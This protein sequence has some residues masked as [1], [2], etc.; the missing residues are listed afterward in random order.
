MT[1]TVQ[2][3]DVIFVLGLLC[4]V[5]LFGCLA[6]YV[7]W[8]IHQAQWIAGVE[9]AAER[10]GTEPTLD[11]L[12]EYEEESIHLGMSKEQTHQELSNVGE[13]QFH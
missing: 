7:R 1:K 10:L 11:G 2:Y 8:R 5:C 6:F 9:K 3:K 4:M 12:G 13:L